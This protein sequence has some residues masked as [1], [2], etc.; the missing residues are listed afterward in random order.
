VLTELQH[1]R[2][3]I[4]H[5]QA[6]ALAAADHLT[7]A[8]CA[9]EELQEEAAEEGEAKARE[10]YVGH[11]RSRVEAAQ[12]AASQADHDA[13]VARGQVAGVEE[14][15][16]QQAGV[17]T[18]FV[19][20]RNSPSV[21]TATRPHR[22]PGLL[23]V[24]QHSMPELHCQRGMPSP[25]SVPLSRHISMVLPTCASNGPPSLYL[26]PAHC[27]ACRL[28]EQAI[29]ACG[30]SAGAPVTTAANHLPT[31]HLNDDT[32]MHQAASAAGLIT[33]AAALDQALAD[34]MKA[35]QGAHRAAVQQ[36][37]QC[38]EKVRSLQEEESR[39]HVRQRVLQ[40]AHGEVAAASGLTGSGGASSTVRPLRLH[41][42][43]GGG[44]W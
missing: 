7:S 41:Q 9:L 34:H 27:P 38:S 42:V 8:Q 16:G 18:R 44:D 36:A 4:K 5:R 35:Q 17:L 21:Q 2:Q 43:D 33:Q 1:V 3:Q 31:Q 40:E 24:Q 19:C 39:A 26:C 20:L 11:L 15:L 6:A 10:L 28:Q 13:A 25:L 32:P 22:Q 30:P 29:A 37:R 12:G 23:L 14:Q